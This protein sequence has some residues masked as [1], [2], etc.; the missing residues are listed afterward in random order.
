MGTNPNKADTD[1]DGLSDGIEVARD[2]NPSD[3]SVKP[4]GAW[5]VFS[6]VNV[7]FYT[8]NGSEVPVGGFHGDGCL[9]S[10]RW[11]GGWKSVHPEV[12][13]GLA[14]LSGW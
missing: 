9:D 13:V 8:L 10:S 14:E 1:G 12:V 11:C 6:A 3:R 7:E 2:G 5:V 4:T